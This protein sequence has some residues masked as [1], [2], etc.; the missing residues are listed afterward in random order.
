MPNCPDCS[1]PVPVTDDAVEG[2]IL[3]CSSCDTELE[4]IALD[5]VELAVAP[6]LA[7]DWG[8]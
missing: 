2:E 8:E 7:E 1:E 6:E 4:V 5:P 3:A